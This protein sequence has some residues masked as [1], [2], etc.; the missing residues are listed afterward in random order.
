MQTK[1][2]M[3]N[4]LAFFDTWGTQSRIWRD[5]VRQGHY[6]TLTSDIMHDGTPYV[7]MIWTKG[8]PCSALVMVKHILMRSFYA[9]E[10]AD[11]K[12]EMELVSDI[13]R[14]LKETLVAEQQAR[15]N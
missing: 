8:C 6:I 15:L 11:K 2:E 14:E 1:A 10:Y 3:N 9:R 4:A 12:V 7:A 5:L 13:I